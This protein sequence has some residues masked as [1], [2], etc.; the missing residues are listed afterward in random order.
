MVFSFNEEVHKWF[1]KG[2]KASQGKKKCFTTYPYK[3]EKAHKVLHT[4]SLPFSNFD[5]SFKSFVKKLH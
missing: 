5:K 4:C 3:F 2:K 1:H